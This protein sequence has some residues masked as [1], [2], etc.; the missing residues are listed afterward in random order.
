MGRCSQEVIDRIKREVS[1]A[2]VVRR[3]GVAL[4]GHGKN[5]I[6]LCPFHDDTIPSL[7]VTPENNLW[8][9]LGAC[10]RGGSV[11]GWVM[12]FENISFT[13]AVAFLKNLD[14]LD[15]N[16]TISKNT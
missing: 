7:I 8:T 2:G 4:H 12:S 14:K 13:R 5:L 11:I 3:S 1:L 15:P 10:G 9:C 6:G 16:A